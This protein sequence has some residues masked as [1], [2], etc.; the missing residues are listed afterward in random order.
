MFSKNIWTDFAFYV[1]FLREEKTCTSF[2]F[3]YIIIP[4][5]SF[6]TFCAKSQLSIQIDYLFQIAISVRLVTNFK[7]TYLPL[8]IMHS[9]SCGGMD[10]LSFVPF[11]PSCRTCP[12]IILFNLFLSFTCVK[13]F[14]LDSKLSTIKSINQFFKG[15]T[16][17]ILNG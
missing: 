16:I 7:G 11:Q 5:R 12:G 3:L 13:Y 9:N 17:D 8:P 15:H 4:L 14:P 10:F 2:N 1:Y 6:R